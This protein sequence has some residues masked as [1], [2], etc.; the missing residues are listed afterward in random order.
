MTSFHP[1]LKTINY[2]STQAILLWKENLGHEEVKFKVSTTTKA[3]EVF[4]MKEIIMKQVNLM[5]LVM[6]ILYSAMVLEPYPYQ[7]EAHMLWKEL[8]DQ[9]LEMR[10]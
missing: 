4:Q 6:K 2:L 9:R 10:D 1:F 5:K 3:T 8:G 7:H